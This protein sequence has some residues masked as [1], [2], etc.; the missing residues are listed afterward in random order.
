[1]EAYIFGNKWNEIPLAN[2][3]FCPHF[4][5]FNEVELFYI[6]GTKS[7]EE[8]CGS[9]GSYLQ[10]LK[11][12]LKDSILIR[13]HGTIDRN[14][15]KNFGDHSKLLKYI[16]E[17]LVT[18]FN[19]SRGYDFSIY[20]RT[21][22]AGTGTNVINSIIQK[23]QICRCSNLRF[24]LWFVRQPM[25]LPVEAISSWLNRTIGDGRNFIG[26]TP[27][28][29]FLRIYASRIQNVAEMCDHLAKVLF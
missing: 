22:E 16:G 18:I 14:D 19:S 23:P 9:I 10:P 20:S 12:A 24:D 6:S 2:P 17:E 25:L 4:L 13:F 27:K 1:M 28:E 21:E 7:I 8:K 11:E 3:T 15:P 26:R 5:R 29:I